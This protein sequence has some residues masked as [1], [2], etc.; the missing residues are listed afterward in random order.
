MDLTKEALQHIESQAISVS[1]ELNDNVTDHP[2]IVLPGSMDIHSLEAHMAVRNQFRAKMNTR[3]ID[4]F[5]NYFV[6]NQGKNC[7]VNAEKMKA[8]T[9][10][11]IGTI[12]EPEHCKHTALLELKKTAAFKQLEF[13]NGHH[14]SQQGMAEWIEEWHDLIT[15]SGDIANDENINLSKAIAAIRRVTIEEVKK[16]DHGQSNFRSDKTAMESI[17]AKSE[18]GLP[19]FFHFTCTPYEG[20]T[21][22]TFILRMN[23][24]K[25]HGSP[26][27]VL[28][29]L[30]FEAIEEELAVEFKNLLVKTLPKSCLTYIGSLE[31]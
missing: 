20:L 29:V 6:K 19:S 26:E 30:R 7:F 28:R 9:I 4:D 16:T 25:S 21:E 27:F 22:N 2:T 1:A 12:E 10:F 24:I 23:I 8:N 14:F 18:E 15:A 11:D 13:S 5:V 31:V 17:E 3:S